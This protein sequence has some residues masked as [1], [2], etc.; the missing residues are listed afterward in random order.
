MMGNFWQDYEWV[1]LLLGPLLPILLL[2]ALLVGL[3]AVS[4]LLR[5]LFRT[6]DKRGAK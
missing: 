4:D 2:G 6:R 1:P 5:W 3:A